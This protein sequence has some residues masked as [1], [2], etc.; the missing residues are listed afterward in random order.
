M[1]NNEENKNNTLKKVI[2]GAAV[3]GA[4]VVAAKV[5]SKPENRERI[6][7]A[8]K[9]VGKKGEE[10]VD[11]FIT[12]FNDLKKKIEESDFSK[13][14]KTE[15]IGITESIEKMKDSNEVDVEAL[16]EQIKTSVEKLRK[17]FEELQKA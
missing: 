5:L 3:V 9:N 4:G 7:D 8:V 16:S 6:G 12:E 14:L 15:I 11:S 13:D 1:S 17:E 10:I 2:A